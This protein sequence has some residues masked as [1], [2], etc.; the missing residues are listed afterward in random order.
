MLKWTPDFDLMYNC[1][2]DGL[3][4]TFGAFVVVA[5]GTNTQMKIGCM[6]G[7]FKLLCCVLYFLVGNYVVQGNTHNDIYF[8]FQRYSG[9]LLNGVFFVQLFIKYQ[10]LR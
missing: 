9:I 6:L 1:C 8:V 3:A 4:N 7:G 5:I 10:K 2:I